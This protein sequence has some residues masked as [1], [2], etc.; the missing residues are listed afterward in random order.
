MF[1]SKLTR[2]LQEQGRTQIGKSWGS[3]KHPDCSGFTVAQFAQLDLSKMDFS[4]VYADF[5]S[6]AK[7]PDEAATLTD[8]QNKIQAYYQKGP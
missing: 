3:A 2:I 6:A 7:L 1:G 5:I 8:I 4:E